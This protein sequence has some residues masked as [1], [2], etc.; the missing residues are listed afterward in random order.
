MKTPLT[1]FISFP[2]I[3]EASWP[4]LSQLQ[5]LIFTSI[6]SK[7][8][9]QLITINCKVKYSCKQRI[10]LPVAKIAGML[11]IRLVRELMPA[12]HILSN[13]P[14]PH[15]GSWYPSKEKQI[16]FECVFVFKSIMLLVRDCPRLMLFHTFQMW[17]KTTF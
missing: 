9:K 17:N 15:S 8:I 1:L 6:Y 3:I 12:A 4:C 11:S 10:V 7:G 16:Q 13:H 14:Q 2:W 5:K